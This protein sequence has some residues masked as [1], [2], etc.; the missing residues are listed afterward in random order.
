MKFKKNVIAVVLAVFSVC[1]AVAQDF[2]F[3]L[4]KTWD[5]VMLGSSAVFAG[6][7][8][9]WSKKADLP[10]FSSRSVDIDD[11]NPLDRHFARGYSES[12]DLASDVGLVSVLAGVPLA[13]YG[14]KLYDGD[15]S[16][17]NGFTLA[18]MYAESLLFIQG[19]K[20]TAKVLVH[21]VRP[22]MYFDD[23]PDDW[24]D[25]NEFEFS[26]FSGHTSDVFMTAG[27]MTYT[28]SKIYPDSALKIP[29]I[30]TSYSLATCVSL[31]RIASGCHFVSDVA[32][33]AV[34]GTLVGYGVPMIH[35]RFAE[36]KFHEKGDVAIMP[37]ASGISFR[38]YL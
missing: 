3:A 35:S 23:V 28:F 11:V 31:L 36:K 9:L 34:F 8:Y 7:G 22:Y 16:L 15:L 13:F 30:V 32:V 20:C 33:G 12:L 24:E 18:A 14:Y 4:D 6:G 1:H 38:M 25:D 29:V 21:R 26:F 19:V 27:F 5:S 2:P 37:T 10:E 17:S